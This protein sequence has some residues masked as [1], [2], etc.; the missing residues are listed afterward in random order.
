[1]HSHQHDVQAITTLLH[2]VLCPHP[3]ESVFR[4]PGTPPPKLAGRAWFAEYVRGCGHDLYVVPV[5]QPY[6][7]PPKSVQQ[8]RGT[9]T[10]GGGGGKETAGGAFSLFGLRQAE[11]GGNQGGQGQGHGQGQAVYGPA[12]SLAGCS[13]RSVV[14]AAFRLEHVVVIGGWGP[15]RGGACVLDFERT[16]SIHV[17]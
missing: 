7:P 1:M 9:D 4:Q 12:R 17:R 16:L 15:G 11:G 14:R 3:Q 10:S 2:T 5:Q 6:S 13:F 8:H